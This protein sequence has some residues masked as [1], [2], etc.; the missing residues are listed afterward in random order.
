[1]SAMDRSTQP[2]R[3]WRSR[4]EGTDWGVSNEGPAFWEW[5]GMAWRWLKRH[6]ARWLG[7]TPAASEQ[8]RKPL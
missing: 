8:P 7:R 2:V 3:E 5:P 6:V 4:F 1:M